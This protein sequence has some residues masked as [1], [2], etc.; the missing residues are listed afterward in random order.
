MKLGLVFAAALALGCSSAQP[1]DW[2]SN[3][4]TPRNNCTSLDA[5]QTGQEGGPANVW[6]QQVNDWLQTQPRIHIVFWGQY[7]THDGFGL[8]AYDSNV[9]QGILNDPSF[10]KPMQEY[11][12]DAGSLV[13]IHV[14]NEGILAENIINDDI[15]SELLSEIKNG[16][17]PTPDLLQNTMYVIMLPPNTPPAECNG[18]V[19]TGYHR[20]AT[21]NN[22]NFTYSVI[23]FDKNG[24]FVVISHEIYEA[25]TDPTLHEFNG[26]WGEGEIGD[27]CGGQTYVLDNTLIQ[28]LWSQNACQC[29]PTE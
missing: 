12:I 5:G 15:Q 26:G 14:S 29:I 16:V 23:E 4:G 6:N 25:I 9:L 13:G 21:Y 3:V 11:G 2:A 17:L 7:W 22:T 1:V 20:W 28:K 19:C 24:G 18:G 8:L 10:Y 27:L